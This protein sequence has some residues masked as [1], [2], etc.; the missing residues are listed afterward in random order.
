M[1]RTLLKTRVTM[2]AAC[3]I[4][5]AAGAAVMRTDLLLD[6]SFGT[7]LQQSELSFDGPVATSRTRSG[8]GDEGYW[9]TRASVETSTPFAKP[10]LIG[11]RISIASAG[12]ENRQFEVTGIKALG[13]DGSG[14]ADGNLAS[15]RLMLVI[16]RVI[17]ASGH[18]PNFVRFIVEMPATDVAPRVQSKAL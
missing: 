8:V 12:G 15:S 10:L 4:A 2:L 6:R 16:C 13:A 1:Q 14:T 3:L 5:A 11:D 18:D 9:L 17:D 7:A